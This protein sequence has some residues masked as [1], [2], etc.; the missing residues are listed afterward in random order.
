M[1]CSKEEAGVWFGLFGVI[2][3][4]NKKVKEDQKGSRFCKTVAECF[5]EKACGLVPCRAGNS[6]NN[7]I[8]RL[9]LGLI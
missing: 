6:N 7:K 1:M 2:V 5:V 8:L 3:C 4:R 9:G